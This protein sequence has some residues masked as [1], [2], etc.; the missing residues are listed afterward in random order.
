MLMLARRCPEMLRCWSLYRIV[1]DRRREPES[2]SCLDESSR[3]E[4]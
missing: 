1:V 3:A 4:V 2:R